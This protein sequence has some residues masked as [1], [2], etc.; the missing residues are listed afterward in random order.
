MPVD[1]ATQIDETID[2]LRAEFE[3]DPWI[4]LHGYSL[5]LRNEDNRLVM[6]GTLENV[7]A[8]RRARVIAEGLASEHWTLDDR[9]RRQ[10]TEPE[11][12]RQIRDKV[13]DWLTTESM[14]REYTLG[15]IT[16]DKVETVQD[17]GPDSH[18]VI[19][20]V[21]DSV[22]TLK[23]TVA[24][25]THRRFA[26]AVSWWCYGCENVENLIEV[27]PAQEDADDEIS[28]AIRIVVEK[29]PMMDA[30]QFQ[31]RTR[32]HVVELQG[33]AATDLIKKYTVMD[34]WSVPGVWNVVDRIQIK[35]SEPV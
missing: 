13:M 17:A 21:A 20:E 33:L 16:E 2:K 9:L 14:F 19:V 31:I 30:D 5:E 15:A 8:K 35:G 6:E 32:D 10:P 28:D 18:E 34:A 7:A 12:D 3:R 25:L 11:G 4:N 1:T 26:E 23:G 24:S 29:D 27:K 22:V